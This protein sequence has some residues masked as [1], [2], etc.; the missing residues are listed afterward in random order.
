MSTVPAQ[1]RCSITEYLAIENDSTSKH[2][3]FQGEV[4]A[5]AG[6]TVRHNEISG[7]IYHALRLALKGKDCRPYN[8]DQ[9]IKVE[10][11]GYFT[12]ADVT[13]ICGGVQQAN[14]DPL[15][16]TNPRV[17]FEVLSPSTESIDRIRKFKSYLQFEA[18]R[19][20]VLV[21]QSEPYINKYVRNDDGTWT[22]SVI[23]VLTASLHLQSIDCHI[24]LADIYEGVTFDA[25]TNSTLPPT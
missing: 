2:E 17:I 21:S 25:E 6:G 9:R 1:R 16:A 7:N 4:I 8:S 19:E 24:E 14:D 15:S 23:E 18:L 10:R 5:M 20:Y 13:V 12:Y 11:A 3:F 22:M